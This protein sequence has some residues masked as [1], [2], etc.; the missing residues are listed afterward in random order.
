[1]LRLFWHSLDLDEQERS[2]VAAA[3]AEL[4]DLLAKP[5]VEVDL[6]A[7]PLCESAAQELEEEFRRPPAGTC[8]PFRKCW[9]AFA[10]GRKVSEFAPLVV[11][12]RRDSSLAQAARA[13]RPMARWG[14]STP[15]VISA[16]YKPGNKY[17]LWHEALHLWGAD[18]C[19]LLA[20]PNAG[21]Q[22]SLP[23]CIMQYAPTKETVRPW[24]FLCQENVELIRCHSAHPPF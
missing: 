2:L 20:N 7:Q 9:D 3:I 6:V 17:I 12:C 14:Y 5:P 13:E 23:R 10:E 16:V 4:R 8:N 19:Y 24:P 18:D 21:P 1:M 11:C 22:C 15:P